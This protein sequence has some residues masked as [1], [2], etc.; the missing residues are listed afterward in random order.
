MKRKSRSLV[1]EL[2]WAISKWRISYT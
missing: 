1:R 2:I